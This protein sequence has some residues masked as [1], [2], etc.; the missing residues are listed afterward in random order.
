MPDNLVDTADLVRDL[1]DVIEHSRPQPPFIFIDLEGV[2]LSRNG[3]IAIMQVLVPPNKKVHLVDIHVLGAQ[4]FETP[5]TGGMTLKAILESAQF[6]KVFFDPRND[7]DALYSH[8]HISLDGVVDLQLLEFATRRV[9]GRFVKGLFKC[10]SEADFLSWAESRQW[11][12]VKEAGQKLFAPEQ[13]GRYEVFLE[14]PLPSA[15]VEYCQQDVL[16]MPKLLL[17]YAARLSP[18]LAA[19]VQA[20]TIRRIALSQ[21]PSFNGQGKHMAVGPSFTY[22]RLGFFLSL[23]FDAT[24]V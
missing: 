13:G 17:S 22:Q 21:S 11:R 1:V 12:E 24:P 23:S 16:Y 15:M 9:R 4:A 19:Q 7:S 3:S 6:S 20:E 10:I 8:F 2:N 5:G 14:R 18:H